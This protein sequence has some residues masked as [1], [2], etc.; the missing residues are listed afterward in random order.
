MTTAPNWSDWMRDLGHETRRLREFLGLSQERLAK[1][2]GVSQGAVSRLEAGRALR[3]PL[4]VAVRIRLVL[5]E[6]L[7]ARDTTLL[8]D[9][10]RW[11]VEAKNIVAFRCTTP[12]PR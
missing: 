7:R 12:A 5:I 10:V 11:L 9:D 6:G 1:A 2:A 3:T 4:L 8:S